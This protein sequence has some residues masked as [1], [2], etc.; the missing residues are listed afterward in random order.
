[1]ATLSSHTAN[2]LDNDPLCAS[3]HLIKS[4]PPFSLF[5][6]CGAHCVIPGY[7][8][9]LS[10]TISVKRYQGQCVVPENIH[11]PPTEGFWFEPTTPLNFQF[12]LIHSF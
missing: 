3:L 4:F 2:S 12:R 7:P 10:V 1:M 5:W 9:G 11:T 6:L 8:V